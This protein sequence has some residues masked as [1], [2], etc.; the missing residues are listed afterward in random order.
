MY[1]LFI[2]TINFF[3]INSKLKR[4]KNTILLNYNNEIKIRFLKMKSDKT[5][6]VFRDFLFHISLDFLLYGNFSD[7]SIFYVFLRPLGMF[8]LNNCKMLYK[9]IITIKIRVD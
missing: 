5:S 9:N 6:C 1:A 7:F 8:S 4:I 2:G 3:V